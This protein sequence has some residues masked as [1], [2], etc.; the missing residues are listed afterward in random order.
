MD[1]INNG[2]MTKIWGPPGWLF[3]HCI[4]MGYP[5]I[6]NKTDPKHLFRKEETKKFFSSLGNVLPCRYCRDS[7]NDYV[8]KSPI[9]DEVLS[10]RK[11]LAKWFY[12]I[13]NRV[14]E[15][16]KVPRSE[17]PSFKEFYERY[18][19]FRSKC[20]GKSKGVGCVSSKDGVKKKSIIKIVDSTGQDYCINT[21]KGMEDRDI[22]K[23]FTESCDTNL[24]KFLSDEVK[25]Q[26][27]FE[28]KMCLE[29]K[30]GDCKRAQL[31]VDNL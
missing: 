15:K 18:E 7:Y 27:R 1:N 30:K 12:E 25:N 13:H 11:N 2:I 20:G 4:T 28:A 3:L 17:W 22:F 8:R 14:N 9:T 16:L 26:I 29:T 10:S 6:L 5:N 21:T 31:I 19:M 24:L 23:K